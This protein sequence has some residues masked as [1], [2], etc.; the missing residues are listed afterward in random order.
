[1][2]V[3]WRSSIFFIFGAGFSPRCLLRKPIIVSPSANVS[4]APTKNT[5]EEFLQYFLSKL[6][7]WYIINNGLRFEYHQP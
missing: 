1:M 4:P 5:A 2:L 3:A 7:V 6:Y